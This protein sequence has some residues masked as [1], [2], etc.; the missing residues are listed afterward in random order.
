VQKLVVVSHIVCTHAGGPKNWGRWG[1]ALLVWGVAYPL[2]TCF[3]PPVLPCQIWSLWVKPREHNYG[4]PPKKIDSL[5]HTFQGHLGTLEV[6]HIDL[7]PV[8]FL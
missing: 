7:Q 6:A 3:S 1:A 2:E 4:D 8:T 5:R